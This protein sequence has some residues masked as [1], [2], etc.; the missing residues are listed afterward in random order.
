[1]LSTTNCI[2]ALAILVIADP[3]SAKL[4]GS[5]LTEQTNERRV[6]AGASAASHVALQGHHKQDCVD[7]CEAWNGG[8]KSQCQQCC[9]QTKQRTGQWTCDETFSNPPPGPGPDPQPPVQ[10][11]CG[12]PCSSNY[13]CA[14]LGDNQPPG[15]EWCGECNLVHGTRGFGTCY[16]TND[17]DDD[18]FQPWTYPGGDGYTCAMHCN[19]D[20]DCQKGGFVDCGT[21]N[22][23]HGTQGYNTCINP[24]ENESMVALA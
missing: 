19:D 8:T 4:R 16:N 6:L 13:E 10:P 17:D 3:A 18:D 23:E 7:D 5:V 22:K 11:Q 1:M 9:S 14:S 12:A 21:C 24:P 2:C 15:S 20:S